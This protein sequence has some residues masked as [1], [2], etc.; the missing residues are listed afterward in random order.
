MYNNI[1]IIKKRLNEPESSSSEK[2][3]RNGTKDEK[4]EFL[5]KG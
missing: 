5:I 2:E 3:K 4:D 1:F